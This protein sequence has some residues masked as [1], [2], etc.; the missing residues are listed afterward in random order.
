VFGI[1]FVLLVNGER[2]YLGAFWTAFSSTSFPNPVILADSMWLPMKLNWLTIDRAY[3]GPT[4]EQLKDDPRNSPALQ[5]A[6]EAAG[7]F[8]ACKGIMRPPPGGFSSTQP[9]D[10]R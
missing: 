7:K 1:P 4:Q 8:E 10:E 6:L 5:K 3:P 2:V 9:L